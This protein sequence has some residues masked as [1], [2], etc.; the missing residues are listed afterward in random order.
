MADPDDATKEV[1]N[2]KFTTTLIKNNIPE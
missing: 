1:D 2:N